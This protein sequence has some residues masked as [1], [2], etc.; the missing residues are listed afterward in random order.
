METRIE[1]MYWSQKI[2]SIK[3]QLLGNIG[4]IKENKYR[5]P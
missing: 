3:Y 1:G 4:D 5:M 2:P